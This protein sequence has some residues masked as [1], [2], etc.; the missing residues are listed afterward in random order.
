MVFISRLT[1][2]FLRLRVSTFEIKFGEKYLAHK[3]IELGIDLGIVTFLTRFQGTTLGRKSDVPFCIKTFSLIAFEALSTTTSLALAPNSVTATHLAG[4]IIPQ[5]GSDL[6]TVGTLFSKFL[7]V[8]QVHLC[9]VLH[10]THMYR[11]NRRRTKHSKSLG[12]QFRL[13]DRNRWAGLLRQSNLSLLQSPY[14]ARSSR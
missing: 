14:L 3:R 5:S 9:F 8:G 1:L 6:D 10:L 11:I 13:L 7:A 4:R 12:S 2:P